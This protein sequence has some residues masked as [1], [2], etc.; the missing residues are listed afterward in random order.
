MTGRDA[1]SSGIGPLDGP[2]VII[3]HGW[4]YDM[5]SREVGRIDEHTIDPGTSS[6]F[7]ELEQIDAGVLSVRYFVLPVSHRLQTTCIREDGQRVFAR[8]IA[9][10]AVTA[11]D[12]SA[13]KTWT[14]PIIQLL[15]HRKNLQAE[16]VVA[17]ALSS[18][19]QKKY[20]RH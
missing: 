3:Q 18:R 14:P 5:R 6:S 1:R 15:P 13:G 19:K 2:T 10:L 7:G 9:D 16:V 20:S 11:P 8:G 12:Q 4:P 17:E